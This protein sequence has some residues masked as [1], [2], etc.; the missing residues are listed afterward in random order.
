MDAGFYRGPD[1]EEM[2]WNGEHAVP[3][4]QERWHSRLTTLLAAADCLRVQHGLEPWHQVRAS[5]QARTRQ[6]ERPR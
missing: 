5:N 4:W 1:G 6:G 3:A 2:F